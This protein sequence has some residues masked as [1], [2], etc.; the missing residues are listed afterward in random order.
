MHVDF[1]QLTRDKPQKISKAEAMIAAAPKEPRLLA[2][3]IPYRT[4]KVSLFVHFYW[5]GEI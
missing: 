2:K 4:A 3:S 5:E 1:E